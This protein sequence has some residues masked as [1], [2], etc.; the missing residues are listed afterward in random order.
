[1]P[2]PHD[3]LGRRGEG[4]REGNITISGNEKYYKKIRQ[5]KEAESDMMRH[6]FRMGVWI[7]KVE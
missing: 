4:R 6:N 7:G 5:G 2:Y 3:I 1:M